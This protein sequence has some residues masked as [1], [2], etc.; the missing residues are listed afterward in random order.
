M[1]DSLKAQGVISTASFAIY[2]NDF[3]MTGNTNQP[4]SI[5]F[6]EYNLDKY[7]L[8]EFQYLPVIPDIGHWIV[9]LTGF[10]LST[11]SIADSGVA[12]ID[13][14]S[15][16]IVA[17]SKVFYDIRDFFCATRECFQLLSPFIAFNCKQSDIAEFPTMDIRL[18]GQ[19]FPLP[20]DAY[21]LFSLEPS[22]GGGV[23]LVLIQSIDF[24][25]WILGDVF[26]R[27][28]YTLFDM[29]NMRIGLARSINSPQ[30]V[31]WAGW[32]LIG[33]VTVLIAVVVVLLRRQGKEEGELSE[34]LLTKET[35]NS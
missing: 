35:G 11:Q 7:A 6:G 25:V 18:S 22:L 1:L 27:R 20:P 14:G 29:D 5:S 17:P 26:M 2:L 13:S 24:N 16:L 23:C 33:L 9:E 32:V 8:S 28:Y 3:W 19:S 4:S 12:V 34:P 21:V 10:S 30:P 15:S 31:E